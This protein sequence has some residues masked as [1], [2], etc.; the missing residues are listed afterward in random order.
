MIKMVFIAS[1]KSG[2]SPEEFKQYWRRT[3]APIASSIPGLARYVQQ[4]AVAP[5]GESEPPFDGIAE[6]WFRD[7]G[8]ME[9]PEFEAAVKDTENFLDPER[10]SGF[11]VEVH[12]IIPLQ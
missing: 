2:L 7:A 8:S 12:E 1:R 9:T 5:K 6:M 10:S 4:H 11:M 3:H